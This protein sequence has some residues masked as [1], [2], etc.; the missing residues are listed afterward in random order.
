MYW[1]KFLLFLKF[2]NST[3]LCTTHKT[4]FRRQKVATYQMQPRRAY[5][6]FAFLFLAF[7]HCYQFPGHLKIYCYFF[8][9]IFPNF[10]NFLKISL[11]CIMWKSSYSNF[12]IPSQFFDLK[13]SYHFDILDLLNCW[14]FSICSPTFYHFCKKKF[15]QFYF[16]W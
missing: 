11:L 16:L 1:R 2:S 6:V 7:W 3:V 5:S 9:E 4:Q 13:F 8:L 12:W 14:N 10:S 15:G